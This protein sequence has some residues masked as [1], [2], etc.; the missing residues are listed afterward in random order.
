M[1]YIIDMYDTG[2]WPQHRRLGRRAASMAASS[3]TGTADLP[4][5]YQWPRPAVTVDCLIYALD[6]GEPWILLIKRKNDPFK[7]AWALPGER[8]SLPSRSIHFQE[9]CNAVYRLLN[10]KFPFLSAKTAPTL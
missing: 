8:A 7:G 3:S 1:D 4:Y 10:L 6:D 2:M 9:F 5:R